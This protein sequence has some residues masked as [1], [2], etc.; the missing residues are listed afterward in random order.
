MIP[1]VNIQQTVSVKVR[2]RKTSECCNV[3]TVVYVVQGNIPCYLQWSRNT[4]SLKVGIFFPKLSS[5]SVW[6][7]RGLKNLQWLYLILL[8]P[9][10]SLYDIRVSILYQWQIVYGMPHHKMFLR[11]C[12]TLLTLCKSGNA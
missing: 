1:K 11:S 10:N 7:L 6:R 9:E 8:S 3:M 5:T 2:R 4:H 12:V